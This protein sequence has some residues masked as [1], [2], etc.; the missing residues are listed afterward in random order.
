MSEI[1]K[2]IIELLRTEE[3]MMWSDVAEHFELC[4]S[5][6][7]VPQG[8]VYGD[9]PFIEC[10]SENCD[11]AFER[12]C[13]DF[14]DET[15]NGNSFRSLVGMLHDAIVWHGDTEAYLAV[16]DPEIDEGMLNSENPLIRYLNTWD[17]ETLNSAIVGYWRD[18]RKGEEE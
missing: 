1:V 14:E 7:G 11:E 9:I 6:G 10:E 18:D 3:D 12:M 2:E 4:H 17:R 13:N 16:L 15:G 5:C 8:N